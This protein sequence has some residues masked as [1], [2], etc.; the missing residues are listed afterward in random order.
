MT[1]H[2]CGFRAPHTR[3]RNTRLNFLYCIHTLPRGGML[4]RVF[5][6]KKSAKSMLDAIMEPPCSSAT[7][8]NHPVFVLQPWSDHAAPRLV[9]PG[10]LGLTPPQCSKDFQQQEQEGGAQVRRELSFSST[11]TRSL[12]AARALLREVSPLANCKVR[13]WRGQAS[14]AKGAFRTSAQPLHCTDL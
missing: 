4:T 11:L 10:H 6:K 9:A 12:G 3:A 1:G 5:F 13:R 7:T 2:P 14:W 8:I